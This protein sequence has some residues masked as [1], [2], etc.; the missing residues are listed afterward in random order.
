MF[1]VWPFLFK[2]PVPA[3]YEAAFPP[4]CKRELLPPPEP[5]PVAARSGA[6]HPLSAPHP[7][8]CFRTSS[9]H[10]LLWFLSIL[11]QFLCDFS[12]SYLL[13]SRGR[14]NKCILCPLSWHS[15]VNLQILPFRD[16]GGWAVASPHPPAGS[17][18]HLHRLLRC[19]RRLTEHW[20][21]ARPP[22]PGQVGE[23]D[24]PVISPWH[25]TWLVLSISPGLC[26]PDL[27]LATDHWT[28]TEITKSYSTRTA[29]IFK[30]SRMK[31]FFDR[32]GEY[33]QFQNVRRGK[34]SFQALRAH[35]VMSTGY[36]FGT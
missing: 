25:T 7:R 5:S 24:L 28:L 3:K 36:R 17:P 26:V 2:I 11:P 30:K 10:S 29:D 33:K 15:K 4:S 1:L 20:L 16:A 8:Q 27:S 12:P 31:K 14:G 18:R 34:D 22:V 23:E 6:P 19:R 21:P 9:R 32:W 13:S 35:G